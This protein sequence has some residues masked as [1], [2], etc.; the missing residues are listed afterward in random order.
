MVPMHGG[1]NEKDAERLDALFRAYR[2]ACPDPDPSVNFMPGLWQRIETRQGFT[3]SFR[4]MVSG[5]V[6]AAAALTL[7]LSVYMSMPRTKNS[8]AYP[9]SYV[10]ALADATALDTP[11]TV[12]PVRLDLSDPGR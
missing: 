4:R 3:F 1:A 6:T 9:V 5:F 10:E 11:D 8:S 7:V 2:A 12:G